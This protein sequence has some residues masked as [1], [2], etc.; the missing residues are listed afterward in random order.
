MHANAAQILFFKRPQ[1]FAKIP[2][3]KLQENKKKQK[4]RKKMSKVKIAT[5]QRLLILFAALRAR[6]VALKSVEAV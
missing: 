4:T 6:K 2:P 5:T 3:T 1:N